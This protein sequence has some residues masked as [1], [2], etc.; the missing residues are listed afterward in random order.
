MC[1]KATKNL[2]QS[3]GK[4]W[5]IRMMDA[6]AKIPSGI[7]SGNS[8]NF[9][10]RKACSRIHSRQN[11]KENGR[12]YL[13]EFAGKISANG[14]ATF[15]M[16]IGNYQH[17]FCLPQSCSPKDIS[18]GLQTFTG[19]NVKI[20]IDDYHEHSLEFE[21]LEIAFTTLIE[22]ILVKRFFNA[23]NSV[24]TFFLLSGLL[25]SY[26]TI[27]E[28]ERNNG[29]INWFLYYF[30]R[31]V[32]ITLVY[33]IIVF[34]FASVLR[35]LGPTNKIIQE[36]VDACQKHS[37]ENLLYI[38]NFVS[39]DFHCIGQGWYLNCDMQMF[40]ITPLI[41]YPLYRWEKKI[42]Y[43]IGAIIV[44]GSTG[45]LALIHYI[46]RDV[47]AATIFGSDDDFFNQNYTQPWMRIQPYMV[48]IFLGYILFKTKSSCRIPKYGVAIGWILAIAVGYSCI[49]ELHLNEHFLDNSYLSIPLPVRIVYGSLHRLGWGLAVGWAYYN[50]SRNLQYILYSKL[51]RDQKY[52][53]LTNNPEIS[54]KCRKATKNLVQSLGK[55]W[56]IRMMDATAKIPSGIFS[57]NSNNFGDRKA[58]SRIHS[59]QNDKENGR[60]YLVE[61][62]GKISA[63]GIATFLMEI[64]NY[65]HGFCLPQSCSPKDISI[66]LQTFTGFNENILVKR[67]FNAFNSVDTFFLLSGLLVSYLTIKEL[68]RNNGTINWF[69]YYFHRYVRITLVYAI[70][71]FMFASVLRHLGPTNK[72]I[73]E[74]V[75]ACQKHSWENLLYIENLVSQDF[76]CI[77]QGWYLNY[78]K[79]IGYV[80]GAIIVLGSTGLL[81]LIH[82]IKRDVWAATIF[83]SD[84][85]FFDQNYTQPW[86]R[87]QPYMVGIFLGYILFKTK[88][89]CRIPKYGVA[90]GW[91]LALAVGYSCIY[92]LHLNEHFLDNSYLSIPLPVR[93]VYGSLHRLG[94]GLAVGWVVFACE[95]GYGGIINEFFI[96]ELLQALV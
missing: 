51:A 50:S 68:E 48:G 29:T 32:R 86:M 47:W 17:G 58:C 63:N 11:D 92:E 6:T 85:D 2:V 31:Y 30:H 66:G 37:W 78:G 55:V 49:Y 8:N 46:K 4:V 82:Y 71:V 53:F 54:L 27:K 61:F 41:L 70:I 22:N 44:L 77:G 13:V 57:G 90:I 38:E 7:F 23:F 73:Q 75:D 59:R 39:Q 67:F 62:A 94:W 80:I 64:G 84:D 60:Y 65:Q 95:N 87:I 21:A 5:A 69:L 24:D 91:I 72:I 40:L 33:A 20:I 45:L 89:S 36:S 96:M 26:L 43:A 15:L 34:M 3:L 56:A 79:K 93:I 28:L 19:F 9:G 52:N 74:S 10:D 81:A 14:I 16:E 83:G 12:Y 18:I 25:V 1:R 88:S 42:G 35:H 76:H